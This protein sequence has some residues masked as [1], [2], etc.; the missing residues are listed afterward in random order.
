VLAL[1][2]VTACASGGQDTAPTTTTSSPAPEWLR[3]EVSEQSV[4]HGG[5]K[6]GTARL[7][8]DPSRQHAVIKTSGDRVYADQPVYVVTIRGDFTSNRGFPG[9]PPPR[10]KQLTVL[11]AQK[12]DGG[13]LDVGVGRESPPLD[14]S[15]RFPF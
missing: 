1:A 13:V 10:G 4:A 2:S 15:Q 14:G 6:H 8:K 12:P 9:A 5:P 3:R 11:F 7:T